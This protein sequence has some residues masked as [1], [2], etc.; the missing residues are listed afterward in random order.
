MVVENNP[1]EAA[2]Q[3]NTLALKVE[4][5]NHASLISNEELNALKKKMEAF[6]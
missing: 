5:L 2:E 1:F 6:P 4:N 3:N